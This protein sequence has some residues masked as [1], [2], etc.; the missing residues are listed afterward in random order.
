[1]APD[2]K[3]LDD[4]RMALAQ[5]VGKDADEALPHLREAAD[6]LTAL[7]DESMAEALLS[8]KVSM[9][10]AGA[11]AGLS[12]NAVPPR[13]A[14]TRTLGAYANEDGRVTAAG[15]ERA[16]YDHESGTPKPAPAPAAAPMRFKPRR[17]T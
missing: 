5:A 11:A 17:R 1:M 10:A 8:G 6:R 3:A 9:R 7:I 4:I 13:L 14:R 12:E 16:K 15:V 2:P